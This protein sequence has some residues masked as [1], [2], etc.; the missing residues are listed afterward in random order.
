[1]GRT[2]EEQETAGE[3]VGSPY[4]AAGLALLLPGLGHFYL[5]RRVRGILFFV[6]VVVA[7]GVGCWLQ[8]NLYTPIPGRPLSRLATLGAMGMGTPYFL[9]RFGLGYSGD[10]MA[11]GHD[12]GTAFL[13]SAG[14]MN[15][16]LVLDAWDIAT[17]RKE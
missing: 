11:A 10:I 13:L 9:L 3:P 8:G 6:L 7:I 12:Y 17:G 2:E 15:L 5:G 16:L 14:L 4:L 1:M